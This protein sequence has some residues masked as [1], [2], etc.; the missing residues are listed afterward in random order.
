MNAKKTRSLKVRPVA[1]NRWNDLE[2]L[3]GEHGAYGGCWCMYFRLRSSEFARHTGRENK[4]DMK[5]LVRSKDVPG[6]LAYV[7]REPVAWV[8]VAPREAFLH[9]EHSRVLKRVD[10]QPVWSLV[11]FFVAKAYRGKGV[12]TPLLQ[13]AV[14]YAATRGA[15][16]VEAYPVDVCGK[17][18]GY[19]GFTGVASVFR[20][21]GFVKVKQV[22]RRQAIMRYA[23]KKRQ[24]G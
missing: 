1:A 7:G 5:K 14:D 8:S 4:R 9:L 23:I 11:C 19:D 10:D 12:M 2:K 6:L 20:K 22:S 16:I 13:A 3:F 21:A 17:L 15:K 24:A 18:T